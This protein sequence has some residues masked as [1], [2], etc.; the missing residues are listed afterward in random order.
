MT[1]NSSLDFPN[2]FT[3]TQLLSPFLESDKIEL[4]HISRNTRYC[5]YY[6]YL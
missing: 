4:L 6:T 2:L 3:S 1:S 5:A